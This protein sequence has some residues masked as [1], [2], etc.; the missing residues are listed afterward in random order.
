MTMR[1]NS[2]VRIV[3]AAAAGLLGGA[4]KDDAPKGQP[5]DDGGSFV[6]APDGGLDGAVPKLDAGAGGLAAPPPLGLAVV[7]SDYVT[8]S[9]SLVDATGALVHDDCVNSSTG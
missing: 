9:V 7:A 5:G 3:I 1:K 4:C 6:G 8:T 2:I